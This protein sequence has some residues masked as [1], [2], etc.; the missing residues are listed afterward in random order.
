ME[1]RL[2]KSSEKILCGVCGGMA[3]YL[4]LDPTLVRVGYAFLSVFMGGF[5]GVLLYIVC[6]IVMPDKKTSDPCKNPERNSG[7]QK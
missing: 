3:E 4:G 6:A 2:T 1:K 5:P 7:Y